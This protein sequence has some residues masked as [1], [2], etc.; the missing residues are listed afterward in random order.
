ML[1]D[2]IVKFGMTMYYVL[3]SKVHC[4]NLENP[5]TLGAMPR[6]AIPYHK[7][8]RPFYDT[9][10]EENGTISNS[11]SLGIARVPCG[12]ERPHNERPYHVLFIAHEIDYTYKI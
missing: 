9:L 2:R 11:F 1:K 4:C 3:T 8:Q 7:P 5:I 6:Y 10:P 12:A